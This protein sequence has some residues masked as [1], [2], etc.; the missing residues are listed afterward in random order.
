MKKPQPFGFIL[1]LLLIAGLVMSACTKQEA[2]FTKNDHVGEFALFS[3]NGNSVPA[4]VSHDGVTMQVR[5]GSFTINA[6]GTCSS[7]TVFVPPTGT[8]MT[9]EVAATYT[10]D[11]SRLTM[12]WEGAGQT[13][14]TIQGDTFT[15]DNEGM[16]F[17]YK[18]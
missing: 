4:S 3:V 7:K 2:S 5:L 8:E 14:G 13:V 16:V 6:D 9:R 10:K 15:M 17:V 12:Q 11:G 18:K 1:F